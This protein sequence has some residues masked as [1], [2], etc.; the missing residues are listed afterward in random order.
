[1]LGYG[2][3]C[4][5]LG[6]IAWIWAIWQNLGQN[7]PQRR[8]SP[9]ALSPGT[10]GTPERTYGRMYRHTDR[11]ICPVFDR[12]SSPSR[13]K[14]LYKL[15]HFNVIGLIVFWQFFS[16]RVQPSVQGRKQRA[17]FTELCMHSPIQSFF[18]FETIPRFK[19]LWYYHFGRYGSYGSYGDMAHF[20]L[21]CSFPRY[22][23]GKIKKANNLFVN[24]SL[25]SKIHDHFEDLRKIF[26]V[27]PCWMF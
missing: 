2:P 1:M 12:T 6:R 23:Y 15:V 22:N 21:W 19:I 20:D 13:P 18:S 16:L 26:Q 3:F 10:R 25:P 7:K 17:N 24:V 14:I 11:Q 8:Q 27:R 4:L 5:D 9:G